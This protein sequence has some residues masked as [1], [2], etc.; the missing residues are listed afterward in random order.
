MAGVTP[1]NS[2]IHGVTE[3]L[4]SCIYMGNGTGA[5]NES[6][7]VGVL[8]EAIEPPLYGTT[9]VWMDG[10]AGSASL[11]KWEFAEIHCNYGQSGF[12]LHGKAIGGK[13]TIGTIVISNPLL[14]CSYH[15]VH[16][17]LVT[18]IVVA[19]VEMGGIGM[20]A[21]T[22]SCAIWLG[23]GGDSAGTR[24][25]NITGAGLR[26]RMFE[27]STLI[28]YGIIVSGTNVSDVLIAACQLW[29]NTAPLL[30]QNGAVPSSQRIILCGN[31]FSI[32]ATTNQYNLGARV[33]LSSNVSVNASTTTVLPWNTSSYNELGVWNSGSNPSR[34][35]LP[36]W[37][38]R[39]RLVANVSW[40]S[41]SGGFRYVF[42]QKTQP[43]ATPV[44]TR[45]ASQLQLPAA[46]TQINV[47][48]GIL[49]CKPGD[50]FE[51]FVEQTSLTA[52]N[53]LASSETSFSAELVV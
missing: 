14:D 33:G 5:L 45:I 20:V 17:E 46:N 23:D 11:V 19:G 16:C 25:I 47:S 32:G 22:D 6:S 3:S 18:D 9:G 2:T 37:V 31:T 26:Y 48:S 1:P 49:D 36:P 28:P 13:Q 51:V 40:D 21:T 8:L 7:M 50:Y 42:I 38:S 41:S 29:G 12:W 30:Y 52:L 4:S 43:G 35:T 53:V 24:A 44:V 27:S 39:V 34:L 10:R 15:G